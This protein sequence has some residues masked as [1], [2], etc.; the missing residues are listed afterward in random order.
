MRYTFSLILIAF[1]LVFNIQLS[2]QKVSTPVAFYLQNLPLD[3][4]GTDSDSEIVSD[5]EAD[6]FLVILVDCSSY[7]STSPELEEALLDFHKQSPFLLNAYETSERTI[8]YNTIFYVPTG[9]RI[10]RDIP[11]WNIKEHGAEGSVQRIME[12]YNDVVVSQFGATPVTNPDDMVGPKGEPL[13]YNLYVDIVYPSGTP[14]QKVPLILNFSSNSPRQKPFSPKNAEQVIARSVILFSFLTNGYALAHA[15]HNYIPMARAEHYDYFDPYS[16]DSR[17]GL[18]STTAYIRYFNMH[19]SQYNL[20]GK[21]GAMG[22]SKASYSVVRAANTKNAEQSEHSIDQTYGP[23]TKPQPWQGYG[24]TIDVGYAAAGDG[25][26]RI[27]IYVDENTVPLITSAGRTDPLNHWEVY[28]PVV[29]HCKVKDVNHLAMWME[30]LGHTYP[31]MG[32]DIATGEKRYVLFKKFFDHYLKPTQNKPL[33]VFY[34]YPAEGARYVDTYGYSRVLAHDDLLPQNMTGVSPFSPVTIRFLTAV[35]TINLREHLKVMDVEAGT[36]VPGTWISSIR[37][38]C[39][40]FNPSSA[41]TKGK[42]YRLVVHRTLNDING[43]NPESEFIRDFTVNKTMLRSGM[44]FYD[45]FDRGGSSSPPGTGGLPA[46][47]WIVNSTIEPPAN[48][49]TWSVTG[50]YTGD[51]VLQIFNTNTTANTGS[52]GRTSMVGALSSFDAIFKPVLKDNDDEITWTFNMRSN[53]ST[54]N[55]FNQGNSNY[56]LAVVLVSSDPDFLSANAQGYAVTLIRGASGSNNGIYR[57]VK[58]NNGLGS[59]NN[60]TPVI[61]SAAGQVIGSNYASVKV[62]YN[63]VNDTWKL[64]VRDDGSGKLDPSVETDSTQYQHAGL[65]ATEATYTNHLMSHCGFLY[66]HGISST[67]AN[68][69]AM[70]DNFGVL[71]GQPA[72]SSLA[73]LSDLQVSLNGINYNTLMM[74]NSLTHDYQY[75]LTKGHSI[76]F[77]SATKSSEKA[78]DP[79]IIQATNLSGSKAERTATITVIAEDEESVEVYNVEFIE[80]DNIYQTG[81][82]SG[83]GGTLAYAPEGWDHS[84]VYYSNSITNGNNK[85]EGTGAVRCGNSSTYTW[86]RLP[87]VQ[88]MG[89]LRFYARKVD[90]GVVGNIKVSVQVDGGDW[91]LVQNLGDID[92]VIYQEFIIPVNRR[93]NEKLYVRVEITKNGDTYNSPGYYF[94]DF[95]FTA[96][97]EAN[98]TNMHLQSDIKLRSMSDGFMIDIESA[99]IQVYNS[100]GIIMSQVQVES[101][102]AFKLKNKGVYFI[103]ILNRKTNELATVKYLYN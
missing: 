67:G 18:A 58:F 11:V 41:M 69:K 45:D 40:E 38:M 2:A 23:N 78:A 51:R 16:M 19:A 39:F 64:Y 5:L 65:E 36:V 97:S 70:F 30:D 62:I 91:E 42:T 14:A 75:Y 86:F 102:S 100:M 61:E 98:N 15:D 73:T 84:N 88:E 47:E 28:A 50:T 52:A 13:N 25:T 99:Y 54:L 56:A 72:K 74:F 32:V 49:V 24:S 80:T 20:N 59:D 82:G 93:A 1:L 55:S 68:A 44:A 60:I 34:A 7:P 79:I 12:V 81:M 90:M 27:P 101:S 33:K 71:Y 9:Y 87:E 85:Y 31:G 57:L 89:L 4:I 43:N 35:D 17:N 96:F 83:G 8:D 3:R 92:N 77:V 22:I 48:V 6:G 76:P 26:R 53:R 10:A 103:R 29:S 21:I 46:M 66:N 95:S 63:P 94:D 37:N